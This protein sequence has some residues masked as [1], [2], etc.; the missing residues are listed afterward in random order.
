MNVPASAKK[1]ATISISDSVR[2]TMTSTSTNRR[3]P[4]A[5]A[6]TPRDPSAFGLA[7]VIQDVDPR[8]T[9][10]TRAFAHALSDPARRRPTPTVPMK[11]KAHR[12]ATPARTRLV[13]GGKPAPSL[14]PRRFRGC[15]LPRRRPPR[16]PGPV[17]TRLLAASR[18]ASG[19]APPAAIC[20]AS[21]LKLVPP[22]YAAGRSPGV[23]LGRLRPASRP[24]AVKPSPLRSAPPP[25]PPGRPAAAR[26]RKPRPLRF[27]LS[28]ARGCGS[29]P[30]R[31]SQP[32]EGPQANARIP[33]NGGVRARRGRSA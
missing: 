11:S 26:P 6:R 3:P 12:A 4:P 24:P 9:P 19:E 25:P 21:P 10:T 15:P 18:W 7:P 5:H 20:T 2:R 31:G 33:S 30:L 27:G 28:P 1:F 29:A 22:V 16:P 32:P 14:A 23:L 13:G 8:S 17:A